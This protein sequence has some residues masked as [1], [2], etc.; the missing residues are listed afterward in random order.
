MTTYYRI[1]G[2][3][4]IHTHYLCRRI[5][6]A[7]E[8]GVVKQIDKKPWGCTICDHCQALDR[9]DKRAAKAARDKARRK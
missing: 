8:H 1:P 7:V 4:V 2:R 3:A 5:W 9:R 6:P